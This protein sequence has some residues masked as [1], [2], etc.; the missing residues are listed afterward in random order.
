MARMETTAL[1]SLVA[2]HAALHA[3]QHAACGRWRDDA[4]ALRD[5]VGG[6]HIRSPIAW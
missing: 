2:V 5:G 3:A 4:S 1:M 6:A